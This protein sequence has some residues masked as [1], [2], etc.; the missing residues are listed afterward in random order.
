MCSN[1]STT[2]DVRRAVGLPAVPVRGVNENNRSLRP[3][4]HRFHR[5][6]RRV[7]HALPLN[8]VTLCEQA[9]GFL[10]KEAHIVGHQPRDWSTEVQALYW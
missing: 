8:C 4:K 10:V 1:T 3:S 7:L 5:S 6:I 2:M 9:M